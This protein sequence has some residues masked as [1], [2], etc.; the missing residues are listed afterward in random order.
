MVLSLIIIIYFLLWDNGIA[1]THQH[2]STTSAQIDVFH[3]QIPYDNLSSVIWTPHSG[4]LGDHDG[5]HCLPTDMDVRADCTLA[6]E[7]RLVPFLVGF[8]FTW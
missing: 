2:F 5:W 4:V 6:V 3:N 7:L 1:N 8:S